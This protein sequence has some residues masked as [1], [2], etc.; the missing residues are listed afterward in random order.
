M[1]YTQLI[2]FANGLPKDSEE[3]R[4]AWGGAARIWNSLFAAYVPKEHEYDSWLANN[5]NDQRLWDIAKREDVPKSERAVHAFIFDRFYLRQEHFQRFAADLRAF[6]QKYPSGGADHLPDWAKALT[7]SKY[8][9]VG[10]YATSVSRNVWYR[11]KECPHCQQSMD[12]TEPIPLTEG[13][14]V[15]DW[16]ESLTP[17]P[18]PTPTTEQEI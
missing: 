3:F 8:E 11:Q 5:G 10:L 12:E 7:E 14:E 13:T 2:W 16:L 6:V 1:S 9:A 4:N 15:Y 17:T 18:T